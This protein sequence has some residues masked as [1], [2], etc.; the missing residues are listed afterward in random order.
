MS[1]EVSKE[2]KAYAS[3]AIL[4]FNIVVTFVVYA[5]IVVNAIA[6]LFS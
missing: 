3:Y 1:N 4:Y 5:L 6:L 2:L